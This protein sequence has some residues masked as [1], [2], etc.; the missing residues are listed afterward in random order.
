VLPPAQVLGQLKLPVGAAPPS[1]QL[2]WAPLRLGSAIDPQAT[3]TITI[4]DL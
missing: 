4:S 2:G 1:L 3:A